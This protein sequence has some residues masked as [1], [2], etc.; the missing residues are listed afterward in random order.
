MYKQVTWGLK[1]EATEI[2]LQYYL[3]PCVRHFSV[4]C[5]HKSS[6]MHNTEKNFHNIILKMTN[7]GG[8]TP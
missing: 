6:Q 3:Q 2:T 7:F 1:N 4:D 5:V 8:R